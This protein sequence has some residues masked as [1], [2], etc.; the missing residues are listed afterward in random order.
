MENRPIA[1]DAYEYLADAYAARID[2]K[3]H[4]AFYERPA[5]LSLIPEVKS[6]RVLDAG[7]G[8][9]VYSEWLLKQ[10]AEVVAIDSSPRMVALAKKRTSERADVRVA[11]LEAPLSFLSD[12]SFDVVLSS[13]VLEY[14]RDWR[15]TF[16]EFRRVLRPEG[17]L[18]VSVTHPFFDSA[19]F[20]TK[21][22][23]D[24]ELVHSEWK[25]FGPRVRMPSY[26]RSMEETLNPFA[27]TGFFIER[28]L[29]PRPTSDFAT[30]DPRHYKELMINPCF[31]CIR[32]MKAQLTGW[33]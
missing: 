7:C 19:Y 5:T 32:A 26:R 8:P 3:P 29:E 4:N 22:Y 31:L 14:V 6:K 11:D 1:F 27:E 13:L 23:F 25:G 21:N 2:T 28:V 20:A 15:A 17:R 33:L 24:T 12:A 10:G 9:G 30:A 16:V 18:I